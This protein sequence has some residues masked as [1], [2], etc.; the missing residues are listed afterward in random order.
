MPAVTDPVPGP[1]EPDE[2]KF[3]ALILYV[4]QAL[5]DDPSFG[6]IKLNKVLFEAEFAHMRATGTPI[7]GV[8]FQRL[9]QGPAPRRLLPVQ[10]QLIRSGDAH[11]EEVT[12]LGYQQKRL[13]AD[14]VVDPRIYF[15][16]DEL[17]SITQAIELL[18]PMNATEA[19]HRSHD[20]IGW[21]IVDEGETI[22]Y[23]TAFLR[24]P[25]VTETTRRRIRE[26]AQDLSL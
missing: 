10:D 11:L 4:A 5:A 14:Q 21:Q 1:I 26:L 6:A 23:E 19:S 13:V 22:P 24:K 12:Y 2:A 25:V 8:V 15:D 20:E 7:T 9:P 18:R 17:V 3:R 16:D